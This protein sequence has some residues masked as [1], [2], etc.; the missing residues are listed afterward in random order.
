MNPSC[1]VKALIPSL[2]RVSWPKDGQH[3]YS[4]SF[5][6]S[7]G[8][9]HQYSADPCPPEPTL[10]CFGVAQQLLMPPRHKRNPGSRGRHQADSSWGGPKGSDK[11][12]KLRSRCARNSSRS[13][14]CALI[15]S[16]QPPTLQMRKQP[17]MKKQEL[18]R[19]DLVL[20]SPAH[21]EEFQ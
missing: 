1:K 9:V 7:L 17:Y 8:F 4:A 14:V 12:P 6:H 13:W 19:E 20:V 16:P 3:G 18:A 21:G 5:Q 2:F 15:S 10:L 11:Q